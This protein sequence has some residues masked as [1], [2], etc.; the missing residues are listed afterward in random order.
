M[1]LPLS[2]TALSRVYRPILIHYVLV[3]IHV[4]A[5]VCA[6]ARVCREGEV[7]TDIKHPAARGD[8]ITGRG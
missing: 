1:I 7:P 4:Y 2:V 5:D 3:R 8:D 6:R